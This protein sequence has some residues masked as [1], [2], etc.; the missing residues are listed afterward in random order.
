LSLFDPNRGTNAGYLAIAKGD[1]SISSNWIYNPSS[2]TLNDNKWHYVA[3]SFNSGVT[4]GS[5]FYVDG[6]MTYTFT[7]TITPGDGNFMIGAQSGG[8]YAYQGY[9]DNVMVYNS[10]VT[11]EEMYRLYA[12]GAAEH[13]VAL[14]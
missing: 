9:I 7:Y 3:I 10:V 12:L 6:N 13:G 2:Q 8:Y 14:K 4:N 11:A 1:N 5:H